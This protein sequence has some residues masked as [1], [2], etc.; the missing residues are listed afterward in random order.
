MAYSPLLC[1]ALS[2]ASCI[3][4]YVLLS[5]QGS[6]EPP[7]KLDTLKELGLSRGGDGLLAKMRDQPIGFLVG[8]NLIARINHMKQFRN[9]VGT[10]SFL[11]RSYGG[12]EILNISTDS[13]ANM[14]L[15]F[16]EIVKSKFNNVKLVHSIH[17]AANYAAIVI[18]DNHVE[19]LGGD[20]SR[21]WAQ[22]LFVAP[23]TSQSI[24]KS[25]EVSFEKSCSGSV[26]ARHRCY[27][28]SENELFAELWI[29][30]DTAK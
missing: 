26:D 8:P 10:D 24:Y 9:D 6:I 18:A 12:K 28:D 15:P 2:T 30:L 13:Y 1:R 3:A 20:S 23:S 11:L 19:W 17:E 25:I 14:V 21:Y 7:K 22:L 27:L 5:G 16:A 29:K 4:M